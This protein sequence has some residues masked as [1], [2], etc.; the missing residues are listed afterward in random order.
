MSVGPLRAFYQHRATIPAGSSRTLK[1][2]LTGGADFGQVG[3]RVALRFRRPGPPLNPLRGLRILAIGEVDPAVWDVESSFGSVQAEA[4]GTVSGTSLAAPTLA[5]RLG[6][7]KVWGGFPF[8]ESAFIGGSSTVAGYHSHRF[9][10]DAS[11]Y[12]GAQGRLTVGAAPLALPA[13]WGVFGNF[14]LGRVYLDGESPGVG[15]PAGG[16]GLWLGFLDRRNTLSIGIATSTEGTLVQAGL[17]FGI[18]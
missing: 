6:G 9:A 18:Q 15:I 4:Q 8:F 10:G 5:L 16:G 14:D 12:G 11:L 3:G 2:T 13:I 1:D 7:R 17:A